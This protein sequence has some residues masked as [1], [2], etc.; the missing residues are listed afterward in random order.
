[1]TIRSLDIGVQFSRHADALLKS[2]AEGKATHASGNIA[3]S[4]KPLEDQ[5]RLLF[6]EALPKTI[7]VFQ[8][9]FFD[10]N[11]SLSN[12]IDVLFCEMAETLYLPPSAGLGQRYVPYSS[13]RA[14]VQ[15]KNS[16]RDLDKALAQSAD[17][18]SYW[19]AMKQADSDFSST[20]AVAAEPISI[21][22]IGLD[23][24]EG[25]ARKILKKAPIPLPAYVFLIEK[26]LLYGKDSSLRHVTD[27]K[28]AEFSQQGNGGPLSLFEMPP[29]SSSTSGRLLMWIFFAVLRHVKP[30]SLSHAFGVFV[31]KMENELSLQHSDMPA[32]TSE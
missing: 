29:G 26:G 28:A 3:E 21:V 9:Y 10:A 15:V 11:M 27:C 18:I 17:A 19:R 6:G 22:V 24:S 20:D 12:Q 32:I 31:R 5:F 25:E 1:M 8:G 2:A 16:F 13:V 4:G 7:G 14:I 23:G 30:K